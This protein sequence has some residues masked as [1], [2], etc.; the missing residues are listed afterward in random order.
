MPATNRTIIAD[1][2][3]DDERAG[4]IISHLR[5][6]LRTDDTNL[7]EVSISRAI[8]DVRRIIEPEAAKRGIAID[9]DQASELFPFV[10]IV[11]ICSRFC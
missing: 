10:P 7:G 4:E 3:K 1:I 5:G 9:S 6:F 11:S 8:A 2:R